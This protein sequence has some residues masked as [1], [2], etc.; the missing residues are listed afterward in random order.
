MI[1]TVA[2]FITAF[3]LGLFAWFIVLIDGG[4]L[5]L[6]APIFFF[7]WALDAVD[8]LVARRLGQASEAGSLFDKAVDRMI[9]AAGAL[10]ALAYGVV[11][12]IV[13]L[14]FAKEWM[15]LLLLLQRRRGR[16]VFDFGVPGKV[17]TLLEGLGFMWLILRWPYANAIVVAVALIGTVV[18]VRQLMRVIRKP[19]LRQG[20]GGH[21]PGA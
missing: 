14:L 16:Q 9:L 6:A 5:G 18:G 20:F 4:R 11:P 15:S 17:L 21:R 1:W 10:A 7:A 2:N 3:R 8:G 13:V 12:A 19:S